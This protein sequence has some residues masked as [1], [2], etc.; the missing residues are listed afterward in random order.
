MAFE[1]RGTAGRVCWSYHVAARVEKFSIVG[2]RKSKK[3]ALRARLVDAD[4]FKVQQSPLVFE[5]TRPSPSG[6][7]NTLRW[8][9]QE[10]AIQ[11]DVLTATIDQ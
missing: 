1:M 9:L 5:V 10:V 7:T 6:G 3:S 8:P 2:I 11:G 4:P